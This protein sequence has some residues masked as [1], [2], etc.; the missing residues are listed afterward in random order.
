MICP[1]C[2]LEYRPGFSQCSDCGVPLVEHLPSA[3]PALEE[4]LSSESA[5]L[6]WQGNDSNIFELIADALDDAKVPYSKFTRDAEPLPGLSVPTI[7]IL[8]HPRDRDVG[9]GVL[10][11]LARQLQSAQT[12]PPQASDEPPSL[13]RADNNE[14][15]E[16]ASDPSSDFVP[17]DFNPEDATAEV[18]SGT[19][20]AMAEALQASLRENGIGCAVTRDAGTTRVSVVPADEPRAREIIREVV[21]AIPPQ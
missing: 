9:R 13:S 18:W 17:E 15:V 3:V 16:K 2:R 14:D 21:E 10:E 8:I 11:D 6:L 19:E 4:Q 1:N 5:E 12:L 20:S 7:A